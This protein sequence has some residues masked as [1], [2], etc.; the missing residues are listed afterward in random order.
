MHE[1]GIHWLQNSY[2]SGFKF[3]AYK[4]EISAYVVTTHK[5]FKVVSSN[6][7]AICASF[8]ALIVANSLTFFLANSIQV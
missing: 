2:K 8:A 5:S 1:L 6:Q 3:M 7:I 4:T